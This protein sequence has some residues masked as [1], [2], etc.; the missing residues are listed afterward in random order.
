MLINNYVGERWH[1][2]T[3]RQK[4]TVINTL[5]IDFDVINILL[6]VV[7]K[8]IVGLP[9]TSV[10]FCWSLLVKLGLLLK[11]HSWS[12]YSWT[13]KSWSWTVFSWISSED[14]VQ[15]DLCGE[16]GLFICE[17]KIFSEFLHK[18]WI[19]AVRF[20]DCWCYQPGWP[21]IQDLMQL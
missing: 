15:L 13:F 21:Q 11:S 10:V 19:T 5:F 6:F 14:K 3:T 8:L 2:V 9:V 7:L 16:K 17:E 18:Q 12:W 20:W 4:K 1:Q